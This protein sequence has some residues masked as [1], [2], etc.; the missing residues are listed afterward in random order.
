MREVIS[1]LRNRSSMRIEGKVARNNQVTL[2]CDAFNA[3]N[4]LC[5]HGKLGKGRTPKYAT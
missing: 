5:L 4:V 1:R 3:S 2:W